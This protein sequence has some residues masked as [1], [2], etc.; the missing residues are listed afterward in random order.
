M[1]VKYHLYFQ[2]GPL[3][4]FFADDKL[5]F[6]KVMSNTQGYKHIHFVKD[7]SIFKL[8]LCKIYCTLAFIPSLVL[9]IIFTPFVKGKVT[10]ITSGKWEV[11]Y[12]SKLTKDAM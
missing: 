2:Y 6:Y 1:T 12:I 9:S 5:S 8:Y 4:I 10:S 11:I 3:P 7:V